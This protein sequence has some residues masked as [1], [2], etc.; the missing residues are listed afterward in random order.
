ILVGGPIHAPDIWRAAGA[1]TPIPTIAAAVRGFGAIALA[2]DRD[3]VVRRAPLLVLIADEVRP[4]FAAEVLRIRYDASSFIIDTVPPRLR[5]GPL[6]APLD[7][8]AALRI[9]PRGT[10]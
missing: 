5:I 1:V 6:A 9:A 2:A 3:G 10:A 8:D 4:G 7:T